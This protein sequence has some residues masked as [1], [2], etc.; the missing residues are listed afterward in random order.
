[1][2]TIAAIST[3]HGT[4]G[5]GVI[6]VSGEEARKIA[7]KVFLSP[8]GKRLAE[9]TGYTARYGKVVDNG[10]E[11]DEVIA[12]VFVAPHSYT[13][14]DVVELSCH[15][16]LYVTKRVLRSVLDAGAH[17]AEPGE[18]TKRAFLNGKV[19]LTEAEAVMDIIAAKGKQ[20]ARAALAGKD[21]ALHKKIEGIKQTLI[22][23]AAHLS[24]WADYPDEDIPQIERESLS[25]ELREINNVFSTL[26]ANYD[27]GKALREGINTVIAGRPNVGKSTLMNLLS[28]CERSIVTDIPGTTRDII[29][30]TV[31]LGDIPLR[32]ADTAGIRKTD[33]IVESIGVDLAKNRVEGAGLVLAVFDASSPLNDDDKDLIN[34][35]KDI[36]AIAIVNKTDLEQKIDKEY[37]SN[38]IKHIVYISAIKGNGLE[39][40]T[41]EVID[42]VGTSKLDPSEALLATERQHNAIKRALECTQEAESALSFGFTLDAVTVSIEGAIQEL[43]ELTGERASEAVVDGVFSRFCVGK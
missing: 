42:L 40:L 38:R 19:D 27:A 14:E 13:G 18:F 34:S 28:G 5:I 23:S 43:L 15:G 25:N 22:G 37:I 6:R 32:L 35:L 39:D 30:E 17:P 10:E 36:P 4:G 21:G 3:A 20:A 7:D 1:M 2:K 26:L 9:T 33:D 41:K 16:G 29:E 12:T 31:M 11:I 24:A 8:F